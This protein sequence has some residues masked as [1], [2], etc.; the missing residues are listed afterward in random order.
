VRSEGRADG[1]RGFVPTG[2]TA[3]GERM[4]SGVALL[5]P[6]C[7]E[8]DVHVISL[9]PPGAPAVQTLR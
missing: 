9:L 7:F 1:S 4:M 3:K 6:R 2:S 8:F 5:R